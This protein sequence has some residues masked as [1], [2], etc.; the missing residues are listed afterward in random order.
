MNIYMSGIAMDGFSGGEGTG[1]CAPPEN[2]FA[3]PQGLF[4]PTP[5]EKF[6][7]LQDLTILFSDNME[8]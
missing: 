7:I 6:A 3:P 2:F 8:Q 5:K 1:G 4:H